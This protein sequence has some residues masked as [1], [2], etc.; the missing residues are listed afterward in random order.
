MIEGDE[1]MLTLRDEREEVAG[2]GNGKRGGGVEGE[3]GW[4]EGEGR[5]NWVC[6]G[7]S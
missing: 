5:V 2:V 6:G 7:N 4:W 3:M 1:C